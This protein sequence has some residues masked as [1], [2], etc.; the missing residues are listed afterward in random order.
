MMTDRDQDAQDASESPQLVFAVGSQGTILRRTSAGWQ[1][2][3]GITT[4][5]LT[6][7]HGSDIRNVIAVGTRGTIL[8]GNLRLRSFTY[9]FPQIG[10][11][12]VGR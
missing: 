6:R 1:R 11:F 7:V 9:R 5:D 3:V 10:T 4:S 8:D 12:W 2:E